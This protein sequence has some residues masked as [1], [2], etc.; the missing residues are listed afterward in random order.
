VASVGKKSAVNTKR[1][2]VVSNARGLLE[3]QVAAFLKSGG[4]VQEIPNGVSGHTLNNVGRPQ[5]S[6]GKKPG[7][8]IR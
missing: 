7:K 2:S 3:E 4:Q 1:G 6:M 8:S 5:I